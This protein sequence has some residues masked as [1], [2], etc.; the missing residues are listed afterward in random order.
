MRYA[1]KLVACAA[2]CIW[3]LQS[4]ALLSAAPADVAY[5]VEWPRTVPET[6]VELPPD[7]PKDWPFYTLSAVV[8][9]LV[10]FTGGLEAAPEH[11]R[12]LPPLQYNLVS[13]KPRV[14]SRLLPHQSSPFAINALTGEVTLTDALNP[15]ARPDS[16]PT[17]W[18]LVIEATV[19]ANGMTNSSRTL[20][21]VRLLS[22][23]QRSKACTSMRKICFG[24]EDGLRFEYSIHEVASAGTVLDFVRPPAT[25]ALCPDLEPTYV[26][27]Q[28]ADKWLDFD[29]GTGQ[30]RLTRP[31]LWSESPPAAS[32]V[33]TARLECSVKG[34]PSETGKVLLQVKDLDDQPP[35]AQRESDLICRTSVRTLEKGEKLGCTITV[36]DRDSM[37]ANNLKVR[38]EQDTRDLFELVNPL[39][40]T[41][42]TDKKMTFLNAEIAVRSTA[43]SFPGDKYIFA[44]TVE[45]TSLVR[46]DVPR[47]V[48]FQIEISNSTTLRTPLTLK[49]TYNVSISRNAT[50]FARILSPMTAPASNHRFRLVLDDG[51]V[52]ATAAHTWLTVTPRT[53]ILY[54]TD[55]ERLREFNHSETG[56][57]LE[58]S[59]EEDGENGTTRRHLYRVEV[60]IQESKD[61]QQ[62]DQCE[63]RLCGQQLSETQCLATCGPGTVD[64]RCRWRHGSDGLHLTKHFS[65]CTGDLESCPDGICDELELMQPTLC[66]QDCAEHVVGEA[67]AGLTGKGIEKAMGICS[68]ASAESCT[69]TKLPARPDSRDI[70]LVDQPWSPSAHENRQRSFG[71]EASTGD[72]GRWPEPSGSVAPVTA[73]SCGAGCVASLCLAG[74]LVSAL[75]VAALV[76]L[77]RRRRVAAK[78]KYLGSRASL[79]VP[80][81][82]VD[83][84]SAASPPAPDAAMQSSTPHAESVTGS[85]FSKLQVDE[86]WEFPRENL[87]LEQSLGEGEF[88]RVVLA[89]ARDIGGVRGFTTV[90]VK[91]LKGNWTPA[92]EQ[93]LLSE[94]CMLKEVNHPNVIR[95]LGGCT[96]KGGPLYVIVEYAQLGS[97]LNVLR[98]SRHMA[99]GGADV[100]VVCNPTYMAQ[101]P[102]LRALE[103][104]AED[105]VLGPEIP[106]FSDLISF[107]YQIAK[108]MAYLADMKLVHRDLAARNILLAEGNV[109]KISDFGLS[110]D[111]Y[112]G[113]TYLK[114]SRGRVPV[115]WMALES[116]EDQI[117]TSKSDVWSFGVVLWEIVTLGASPYPGVGPEHLFRLLKTG[118]RM[119]QPEG[120][121]DELYR[122]MLSCWQPRPQDRPCF[123]E[124]KQRLEDILQDAAS[125]L[126]LGG[127]Q[128]RSYYNL[129]GGV[130]LMKPL[131]EDHSDDGEGS[132]AP[133]YGCMEFEGRRSFSEAGIPEESNVHLLTKKNGFLVDSPVACWL[134]RP[135]VLSR[136]SSSTERPKDLL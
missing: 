91:M 39:Y 28:D 20:L 82:Y 128:N 42:I 44:V 5:R 57:L 99:G 79:S 75:A 88:G 27:R 120:C 71:Q 9:P 21:V 41:F 56:V 55:S 74:L 132:E 3:G 26:L 116:L 29:R 17:E 130:P 12:S 72:L 58:A 105:P 32:S 78:H 69:C 61:D 14:G 45:D 62:A 76:A 25:R 7:F 59:W 97:L 123:K 19:N 50:T 24:S 33:V 107:A 129:N 67:V 22:E 38:L 34:Q 13:A 15:N 16:R 93:D 83:S 101:E 31:V 64:G 96:T 112:E 73:T 81:D 122:M 108:G 113:D 6:T 60:H 43:A 106:S 1:T 111:V 53:G 89:R 8:V 90:A 23:E 37:D 18:S 94:F 47:K 4:S 2:V 84:R 124:L 98:R 135:D 30:L 119:H 87:I 100:T 70:V 131:L 86:Q 95:L 118:Y 136:D 117:Y 92:E 46:S 126:E 114:K 54:V 103:E 49:D 102:S 63:G 11:S 110:R 68:C 133:E 40:Q 35:R 121:T 66:P 77:V 48:T 80:S 85:P 109:I 52:L 104:N 36:R 10:L 134:A 125:Y 51:D 115:K 127:V 65:T